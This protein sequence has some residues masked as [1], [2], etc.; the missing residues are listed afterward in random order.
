MLRVPPGIQVQIHVIAQHGRGDHR[1]LL[2]LF[3]ELLKF[4]V[5]IA[6]DDRMLFDPAD[7]IFLSLHLEEAAAVLEHLERLPI[8]HFA[9]AIGDRGHAV[10][11]VHLPRGNIHRV[12]LLMTNTVAA[13]EKEDCRKNQHHKEKANYL[14]AG[15]DEK[16]FERVG[17]AGF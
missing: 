17:T 6:V 8:G 1:I 13:C 11:Q 10:V 9:H 3:C 7:L 12:V 2:V 15:G 14:S 16:N 4:V 5:Q